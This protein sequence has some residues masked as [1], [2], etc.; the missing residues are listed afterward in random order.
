[1]AVFEIKVVNL[2]AG[3]YLR[4]TPEKDISKADKERRICTFRLAWSVDRLL[5]QWSTLRTE[6]LEQRP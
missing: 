6:Y 5:L 4:M 2:N 1:M 3:Y